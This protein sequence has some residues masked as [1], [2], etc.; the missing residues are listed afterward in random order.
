MMGYFLVLLTT[1]VHMQAV[2][3]HTDRCMAVSMENSMN[4]CA[5]VATV[6]ALLTHCSHSEP[7]T[8]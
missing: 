5:A 6:L 7:Q 2:C 8:S 4:L 1:A 3:V